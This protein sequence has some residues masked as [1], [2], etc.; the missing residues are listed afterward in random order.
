MTP[1]KKQKRRY[2]DI[3]QPPPP[4]TDFASTSEALNV[5]VLRKHYPNVLTTVHI[6]PYAV[7]YTFSATGQW[8]KTGIEGTLFIVHQSPE[9]IAAPHETQ[10]QKFS[11]IILNRRGLDNFAA[12]LHSPEYI[13]QTEEFIILSGEDENDEGYGL[14]IFAEP[15]PSSTA[16]MRQ[17]TAQI[18]TECARIA[19][20]SMQAIRIAKPARQKTEDETPRIGPE[21]TPIDQVTP[22]SVDMGRQLSLRELFG[23]QRD[24]D[25]GFTVH[26]HHTHGTSQGQ[27]PPAQQPSKPVAPL[28]QTN[29]DTEFFR[30][31]TTPVKGSR[32]ATAL[33]STPGSIAIEDLF[34]K[35]KAG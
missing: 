18:M 29:P 30:S 25:A 16:H 23:Q 17:A 6:A 20:E 26:D 8:E 9:Y 1:L 24:M 14:W 15:P 33:K 12:D 3:V 11:V 13:E 4:T 27:T 21:E 19:A 28:F 35:G 10:P 31:G 5:K 22:E 2:N 34:K 32:S 7:L